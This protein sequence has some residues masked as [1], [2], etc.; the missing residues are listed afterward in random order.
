MGRI[1]IGQ[2]EL[3]TMKGNIEEVLPDGRFSVLLENEHEIIAYTAGKMCR[4]RI[5]ARAGNAFT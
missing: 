2:E 5:R 4:F 1:K 3:L